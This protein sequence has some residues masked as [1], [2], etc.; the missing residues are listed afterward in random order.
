MKA[1]YLLHFLPA[2]DYCWQND[3]L[4]RSG[5]PL[6]PWGLLSFSGYPAARGFVTM[7]NHS[8]F[9]LERKNPWLMGVLERWRVFARGTVYS[10]SI[11]NTS[12]KAERSQDERECYQCWKL[13][14]FFLFPC[15]SEH[16]KRRNP[17]FIMSQS[18][19]TISFVELLF[20]QIVLKSALYMKNSFHR[21]QTVKVCAKYFMPSYVIKL[22][23]QIFWQALQ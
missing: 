22:K 5:L 6:A 15:F 14:I 12:G 13:R 20:W 4:Q 7:Q 18:K 21:K 17:L 2:A 9:S 10:P 11:W 3:T 19:V 1:K 16:A 23:C 8:S